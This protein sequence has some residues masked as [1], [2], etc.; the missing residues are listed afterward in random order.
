VSGTQWLE[1]PSQYS[2]KSHSGSTA[3][4]Q[5]VPDADSWGQENRPGAVSDYRH[6]PKKMAKHGWLWLIEGLRDLPKL[7]VLEREKSGK[8]PAGILGEG[9]LSQIC[10]DPHLQPLCLMLY[11]ACAFRLEQHRTTLPT[12]DVDKTLNP[13]SALTLTSLF[14]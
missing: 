2:V 1:D 14:V 8:T 6:L 7:R 4:L 3:F 9:Q 11:S 13:V 10:T 5:G 12:Y